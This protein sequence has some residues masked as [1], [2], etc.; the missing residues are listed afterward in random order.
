MYEN[1]MP[2]PERNRQPMISPA[3][4]TAIATVTPVRAP[5]SNALSRR[6]GPSAER[7]RTKLTRNVVATAISAAISSLKPEYRK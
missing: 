4:A 5:L 1:F 6:T 3:A 2:M 7:R